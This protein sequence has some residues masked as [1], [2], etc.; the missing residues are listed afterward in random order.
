MHSKI[1]SPNVRQTNG[2]DTVSSCIGSNSNS[3]TSN[4][5]TSNEIGRR[6]TEEYL[7]CIRCMIEWRN[8]IYTCLTSDQTLN[9]SHLLDLAKFLQNMAI[10]TQRLLEANVDL[11]VFCRNNNEPREVY[12][13]HKL[14]KPFGN[15][16]DFLDQFDGCCKKCT[17]VTDFIKSLTRVKISLTDFPI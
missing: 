8:T 13:S 5:N 4:S 10:S 12:T 17:S 2:K 6:R 3:S 16:F 14:K 11:C 9:A 1:T 7:N 15:Y